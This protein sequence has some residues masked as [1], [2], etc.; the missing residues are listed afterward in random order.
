MSKSRRQLVLVVVL[1]VVVFIFI[2]RLYINGY[3]TLQFVL[4]DQVFG[5]SFPDQHKLL[6]LAELDNLPQNKS[7][8]YI[9]VLTTHKYHQSRLSRQFVTWMQTV[10]SKQVSI[11]APLSAG[12]VLGYILLPSSSR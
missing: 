9:S 3:V 7:D 10:D 11:G 6:S 5:D 4:I 2:Y 12:A 8:I 1:L